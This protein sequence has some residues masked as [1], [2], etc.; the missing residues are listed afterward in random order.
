MWTLTKE[1]ELTMETENPRGLGEYPLVIFPCSTPTY[2]HSC[3]L[4]KTQ[5]L[6]NTQL[7]FI[8]VL[9][10]NFLIE[11]TDDTRNSFTI[12][13][14][15]WLKIPLGGGNNLYIGFECHGG[16][17]VK[18][19]VYG[20]VGTL[21]NLLVRIGSPIIP[22]ELEGWAVIETQEEKSVIQLG[23]ITEYRVVPI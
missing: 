15:L 20:T 21:T 7:Q 1:G 5:L 18:E 13:E 23:L 10:E 3:G 22:Q 12:G 11:V 2:A 8:G 9:R 4:F 14:N 19:D 6:Q 16:F 17:V